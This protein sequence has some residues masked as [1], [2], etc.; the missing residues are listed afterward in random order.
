MPSEAGGHGRAVVVVRDCAKL[1]HAVKIV[2]VELVANLFV[3][4]VTVVEK[5][6]SGDMPRGSELGRGLGVGG[7]V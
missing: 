1:T 5:V 2:F 3:Q 4:M 7:V 6:K